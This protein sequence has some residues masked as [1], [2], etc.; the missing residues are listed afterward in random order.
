MTHQQDYDSDSK[1]NLK[2]L[3][4][5][6]NDSS[7]RDSFVN[8]L[9]KTETV[10]LVLNTNNIEDDTEGVT[11]TSMVKNLNDDFKKRKNLEKKEKKKKSSE[12]EEFENN[13][14]MTTSFIKSIKQKNNIKEVNTNKYS[15]VKS[16]SSSSVASRINTFEV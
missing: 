2:T 15:L 8:I 4:L 16:S 5:S 9:I 7:S 10:A 6:S 12:N 11:L 13:K 3:N 14:K 1:I